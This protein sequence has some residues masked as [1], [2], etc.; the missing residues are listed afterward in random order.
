M[1]PW[2]EAV[3]QADPRLGEIAERVAK[4]I[5]FAPDPRFFLEAYDLPSHLLRRALSLFGFRGIYPPDLARALLAHW[6]KA[7]L[8]ERGM[9]GGLIT[10]LT[11]KAVGDGDWLQG[12]RFW[13]RTLAR[14]GGGEK[15]SF[16]LSLPLWVPL[17]VEEPQDPQEALSVLSAWAKST[18]LTPEDRS[19]LYLL[20]DSLIVY[21]WN[22][23]LVRLKGLLVRERP[24]P[25]EEALALAYLAEMKRLHS[26]LQE[27]GYE[28]ILSRLAY[29]R[30]EDLPQEGRPLELWA[31]E[32]A[33]A[34]LETYRGLQD[35][36]PA[37]LLIPSPDFLLPLLN[38]GRSPESFAHLSWEEV[39]EN[40]EYWIDP[41]ARYLVVVVVGGGERPFLTHIP[42]RKARRYRLPLENL[43]VLGRKPWHEP[44]GQ[45]SLSPEDYPT[46]LRVAREIGYPPERFPCGL[47]L[48]S[49]PSLGVSSS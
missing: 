13:V 11:L 47:L 17:W 25:S 2:V 37:H 35:E 10:A 46:L 43:P 45:R 30:P 41:L 9:G 42:Y 33:R 22:R 48:K 16:S 40:E 44:L 36:I 4:Q 31:Q 29:W 6:A 28:A 27:K 26:F 18:W 19:F 12:V 24:L 1:E 5:A 39:V 23:G 34:W 32:R 20:K 38:E 3:R 7:F 15:R 49:V 8:Q 14:R 21:L